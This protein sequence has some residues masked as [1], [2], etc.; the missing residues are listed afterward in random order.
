M[1]RFF[2]TLT[3]FLLTVTTGVNAQ[4]TDREM[5]E[6]LPVKR[7]LVEEYTGLWCSFCPRGFVALEELWEEYGEDF[8]AISYHYNDAMVPKNLVDNFPS[9]VTSYPA[10]SIDRVSVFDPRSLTSSYPRYKAK[11]A[12]AYVDVVLEWEDEAKTALKATTT[13][14]FIENIA[15]VNFKIAHILIADGLSNPS[16]LQNNA[17]ANSFDKS[18]TGKW[19]DLFTKGSGYVSGLTFNMVAVYSDGTLGKGGI[20]P[21]NVMAGEPIVYSSTIET[22]EVVNERGMAFVAESGSFEKVRMVSVL[23]D[24]NTGEVVNS[25]V[26]NYVK[27]AT[28]ENP[29][30]EVDP[31]DGEDEENPGGEIDPGDGGDE[32]NPGGDEEG[33]TSYVGGVKALE[34]LSVSYLDLNGCPVANP[35]DGLYLKV[36]TLSDGS[37]RIHKVIL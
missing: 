16:W 23:I 33:E 36:E 2:Y 18:L 35:S 24:G 27:G 13:V 25:N 3:L 14:K 12:N 21:E 4:D 30:E 34:I 11:T 20:I 28:E 26:S 17:F 32:E 19:W 6:S 7:P 22:S 9:Y 10:S 1:K 8:V 5:P 37:R 31:G 29:G 15:G